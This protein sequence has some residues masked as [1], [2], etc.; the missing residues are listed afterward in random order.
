MLENGFVIFWLQSMSKQWES[1]AVFPRKKIQKRY[2][3]F[4]H[5]FNLPYSVLIIALST[6]W[7][8]I[9]FLEHV[10]H[11]LKPMQICMQPE[12]NSTR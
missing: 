1:T 10:R 8:I 7:M 2:C 4:V 12:G 9:L 11:G 3:D 5:R 6:F